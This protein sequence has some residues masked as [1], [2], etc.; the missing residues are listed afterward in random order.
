MGLTAHVRAVGAGTR[1][2]PFKDA[3]EALKRQDWAR[4]KTLLREH[5]EIA[6]ARGTNGNTLL[7]LETSM[8]GV[9]RRGKARNPE[10]DTGLAG[11]DALL[12]AGAD[13]NEPNDRGWTPPKV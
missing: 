8:I 11:I 13:P 5:P 1:A 3:F 9:A 6:R 2:E 10:S 4:L 12:A 7:N